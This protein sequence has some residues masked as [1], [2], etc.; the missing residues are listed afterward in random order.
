[1]KGER[2]SAILF[3]KSACHLCKYFTT[4]CQVATHQHK[5]ACNLALHRYISGV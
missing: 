2:K 3:Y 5:S 1:M 4:V